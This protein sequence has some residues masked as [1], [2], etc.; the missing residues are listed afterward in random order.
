MFIQFPVVKLKASRSGTCSVCHA[1]R[2]RARTFEQTL[3]PWNKNSNGQPKTREEAM[4]ELTIEAQ[5]WTQG[6][7]VCRACESKAEG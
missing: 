4:A 6:P 3:N 5:Q 1:G 7:L 2:R